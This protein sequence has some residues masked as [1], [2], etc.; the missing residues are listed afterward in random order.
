MKYYLETYRKKANHA[1][2]KA[3]DDCVTIMKSLG[4]KRITLFREDHKNV[5]KNFSA[6]I[7]NNQNFKGIEA[8]SIIVIEHPLY[9]HSKYLKLLSNW[10]DKLQLKLIFIVHDLEIIRNTLDDSDF[11][12][13]RDL[14]M[15]HIADKIIVHNNSMANVLIKKFKVS[16]KKIVILGIFDYLVSS[17]FSPKLHKLSKKVIIAGNLDSSKVG[18]L[19]EI[20]QLNNISFELYGNKIKEQYNNI[21]YNG[22]FKPDELCFKLNG[23]FGLV[24]DGNTIST[25][26]GNYGS[27]LKYNDPHKLSLYLACAIPVIVWKKSAVASFVEKNHV[28]ITVNSLYELN[29]RISNL[30]EAEYKN[31][32][33]N[34]E[35][36]SNQV[37]HGS[38][39]CHALTVAVSEL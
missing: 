25:C 14:L 7:K 1:G 16:T 8:N 5:L 6:H 30:S 9:I 3:V 28:G 11:Y 19:K 36:I 17:G 22:S 26:S 39:L 23:S 2:S 12:A 35:N 38:Y 31:L 18:Y 20:N 33:K 15:F 37:R 13:K 29:D 21:H 32:C 24:W 10:K 27:Y 4:F 34:A